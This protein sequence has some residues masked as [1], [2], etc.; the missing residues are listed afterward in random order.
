MTDRRIFEYWID[1]GRTNGQYTLHRDLKVTQEMLDNRERFGINRY[2]YI[3]NLGRVYTEACAR[4][5]K[6]IAE[7]HTDGYAFDFAKLYDASDEGELRHPGQ[8]D[9]DTLWFGKYAG[10]DIDDVAANDRDYLI[11]LRDNFSRNGKPRMNSLLKKLDEMELG[12]SE[13]EKARELA[14]EERAR[15]EAEYE[16]RKQPIPTELADGRHTFSGTIIAIYHRETEW[17]DQTKMIFED[18]RGF[19]LSSTAPAGLWKDH[20]D[21]PRGCHITFDAAVVIADDDAC[22]GFGKRPTKVAIDNDPRTEA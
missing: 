17:G 22:F 13:A 5:D 20:S 16:K 12:Q 10:S 18:D 1:I 3:R 21:S 14:E 6:Y 15:E 19:K 4:A 11:Y 2:T 8:Y 7:M 9:D